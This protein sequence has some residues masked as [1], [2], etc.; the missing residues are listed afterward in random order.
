[1]L[2]ARTVLSA[3]PT[4]HAPALHTLGR[5]MAPMA[6][7]RALSIISR[8][9]S[10]GTTPGRWIVP[11]FG[12]KHDKVGCGAE[13]LSDACRNPDKKRIPAKMWNSKNPRASFATG[14][15]AGFSSQLGKLTAGKV[16]GKVAAAAAAAATAAAAF[17]IEEKPPEDEHSRPWAGFIFLD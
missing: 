16:H 14:F 3:A 4:A 6:R 5:D 10:N 1:M 12:G 9:A 8:E 2:L 11:P 17:L 13:K 7:D 15:L